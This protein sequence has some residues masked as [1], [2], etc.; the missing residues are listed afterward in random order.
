MWEKTA[1]A[2][3]YVQQSSGLTC[4]PAAA[5][6]LLHHYAIPASEGEM[7]YLAGTSFFGT[8]ALGMA[9]ALTWKTAARGWHAEVVTPDFASCLKLTPFIAHVHLPNIGGHA[10]L[11]DKADSDYVHVIDP[12]DGQRRKM[13]REEFEAVWLGIMIHIRTNE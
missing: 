2:K 6:M 1:D 13:A 3:G 12:L 8:D 11:V 7:A 9:R 10:L 5:V 4:S